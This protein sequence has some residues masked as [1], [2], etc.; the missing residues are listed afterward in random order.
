MRAA[1]SGDVPRHSRGQGVLT[2]VNSGPVV[3]DPAA[4]TQDP[5]GIGNLHL[6][7]IRYHCLHGTA[8]PPPATC[9]DGD[10]PPPVVGRFLNVDTRFLGITARLPNVPTVPGLSVDCSPNTPLGPLGILSPPNLLVGV[11]RGAAATFVDVDPIVCVPLFLHLATR[12]S[13]NWRSHR[14]RQKCSWC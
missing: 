7:S 11:D 4:E 12:I 9:L 13:S 8:V 14:C 2:T 10:L 1:L 3:L 5:L 6:P